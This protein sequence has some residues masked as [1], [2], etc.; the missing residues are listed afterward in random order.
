MAKGKN[1]RVPRKGKN[2]RNEKH[3]FSKKVWFKL[4]SPS[5]LKKNIVV[6]WTCCKRPQGTEVISDFLKGRVA[7]ICYADITE[8]VQDVNKK[9]KFIVDEIHGSICATN[10]YQF[11]LTKDAVQEQLRKRQ[12]LV[13]VFADVKSQDGHVYR[14]F[15]M[16]VT[17]QRRNQVKLN[18]YAKSSKVKVI[19]K[20]LV[21]ELVNYASGVS[22]NNLAFEV[23][24]NVLDK[25]LQ[26]IANNV[27][28]GC[29]LQ[30][31]K[32]KTTKRGNVDTAKLLK[33][34]QDGVKQETLKLME[35]PEAQNALT[36]AAEV[37][38]EAEVVAEN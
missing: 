1:K 31:F 32:M 30:I 21:N 15:V 23:I 19:R 8:N 29:K 26:D 3:T 4:I 6:G 20:L 12:S 33:D 13:N 38:V 5:A 7:E 16:I 25:K 10:F 35:N 24:T 34:A 27:L 11:E 36:K 37:E 28:P 9:I 14:I 17:N 22:G 18:S 2:R